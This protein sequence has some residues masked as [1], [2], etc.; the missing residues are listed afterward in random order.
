MAEFKR[1]YSKIG[2]DDNEL[3]TSWMYEENEDRYSVDVREFYSEWGETLQV[4]LQKNY[5][6]SFVFKD[7]N[8]NVEPNMKEKVTILRGVG[9]LKQHQV[10]FE[11]FP[12]QIHIVDNLDLYHIWIIERAKFPYYVT[13]RIPSLRFGWQKVTVFQKS[14]LYRIKDMKSGIKICYV[15]SYD[16]KELGWWEKQ[17][18]KDS[19]IGKDIVAVELIKNSNHDI[20]ILICMPKEIEKL[21]FGLIKK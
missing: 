1:I 2:G 10:G 20:S 14:Y 16:R 11:V 8:V 19:I 4:A 18:F 15:K 7:K 17:K 9:A 21:P 6:R 3:I 5:L 13:A 12:A